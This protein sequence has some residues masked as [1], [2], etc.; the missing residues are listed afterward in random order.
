M[1]TEGEFKCTNGQCI[2]AATVCDLERNCWDGSDELNCG[3]YSYIITKAVNLNIQSVN[4]C[5][6][7]ENIEGAAREVI[8]LQGPENSD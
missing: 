6:L 8:N 1:C 4:A 3:G 5:F 2:P 7:T